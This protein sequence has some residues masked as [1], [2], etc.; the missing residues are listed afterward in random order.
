MA[1]TGCTLGSGCVQWLAYQPPCRQARSCFRYAGPISVLLQRLKF[2][3]DTGA[4]ALLGQLA[5]R[6]GPD[7][8]S[9]D[10]DTIIPVPLHPHRLRQRG[11]NQSSVLAHSFF[12][13]ARS[14]IDTQTMIRVRNTMAQTSL[15]GQARRSNLFGAF[16]IAAGRSVRGV[17][18]CLIDDV[19]TTGTTALECVRTLSRAGAAGV[20]VWTVARAG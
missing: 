3:H 12:P 7:I 19:F 8:D 6:Y 4:A 15:D 5:R 14:K 9:R 2:Q 11:L 18:V 17:S 10:Y 16:E 1:A 20:D 13:E